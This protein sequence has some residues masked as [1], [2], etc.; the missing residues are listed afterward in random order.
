MTE[1]S[2]VHISNTLIYKRVNQL[3]SQ[4][5]GNKYRYVSI[6]RQQ[7]SDWKVQNSHNPCNPR[8]YLGCMCHWKENTLNILRTWGWAGVIF[9]NMTIQLRLHH[10]KESWDFKK[11]VIKI[12]WCDATIFQ[13]RLITF[14]RN[15]GIIS[16][17]LHFGP[18]RSENINSFGGYFIEP[19]WSPTNKPWPTPSMSNIEIGD[20]KGVTGEIQVQGVLP[21]LIRMSTRL[22]ILQ[23]PYDDKAEPLL[24]PLHA[25]SIPYDILIVDWKFT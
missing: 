8:N 23:I 2:F 25:S 17:G 11:K 9:K 20:G 16:V 21:W 1:I 13:Q 7:Y 3:I 6:S 19:K 18:K 14:S 12:T 4:S 22:Q 24:P 5:P 10:T 15:T